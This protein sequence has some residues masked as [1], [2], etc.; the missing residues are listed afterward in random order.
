MTYTPVSID[1]LDIENPTK[2]R[3]K[4]AADVQKEFQDYLGVIPRFHYQD[5]VTRDAGEYIDGFI[6]LSTPAELFA[7]Y[8]DLTGRSTDDVDHASAV[9]YSAAHL[10]WEALAGDY[11]TY[12]DESRED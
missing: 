9:I 7:T 3:L 12:L 1:K 5:A 11:Q 2:G 10:V 4:F 6:A 8:R